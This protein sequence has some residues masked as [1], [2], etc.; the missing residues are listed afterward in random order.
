M[1]TPRL[2][3]YKLPMQ[4]AAALASGRA[5]L[6]RLGPIQLDEQAQ[7]ELLRLLID[8]IDDRRQLA[9]AVEMLRQTVHATTQ[10]LDGQARRLESDMAL[11]LE[12][13]RVGIVGRGT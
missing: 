5:E 13:T 11:L 6:L 4:V 3:T 9:E 1:P 10:S 8:L 7:K 12:H 2:D